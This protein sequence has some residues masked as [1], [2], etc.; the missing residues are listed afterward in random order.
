VRGIRR[1]STFSGQ[2]HRRSMV[3]QCACTPA[4]TIKV[5]AGTYEQG[6]IMCGLCAR[7]FLTP[8]ESDEP[9][10]RLLWIGKGQ[11]A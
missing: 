3:R 6:Y 7:P 11:A 10:A 8:G 5:S 2:S 1:V 4:R 9:V